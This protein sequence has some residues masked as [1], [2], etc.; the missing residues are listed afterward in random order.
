VPRM[1]RRMSSKPTRPTSIPESEPDY[2]V[3][4]VSVRT[5][6][7]S[8]DVILG[9]SSGRIRWKESYAETRE[10]VRPQ[11]D[12]SEETARRAN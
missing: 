12:L 2:V 11:A 5:L 6:A 7:E 9:P 4:G 1:A 3:G 8:A 10:S